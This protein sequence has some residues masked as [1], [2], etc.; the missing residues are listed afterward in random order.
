MS[1]P[2]SLPGRAQGGALT[3]DE[4]SQRKETDIPT[5]FK[6]G[7]YVVLRTGWEPALVMNTKGNTITHRRYLSTGY[8]VMEPRHMRDFLPLSPEVQDA[9]GIGLRADDETNPNSIEKETDMN[10]LYKIVPTAEGQPEEYGTLLT[11]DS[12]GRA[13]LEMKGGGGVKSFAFSEIEEVRPYTVRFRKVNAGYAYEMAVEKGSLA[14]GDVLVGGDGYLYIV[15]AIN[16]KKEPNTGSMN[17]LSVIR[18]EPFNGFTGATT[19]PGEADD[20]ED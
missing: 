4:T 14:K 15:T 2:G 5:T 9:Y 16:T 3:P 8:E 7:D 1:K 19:E 12:T 20:V 13:V 6:P 18:G 11:K 17:I 10:K